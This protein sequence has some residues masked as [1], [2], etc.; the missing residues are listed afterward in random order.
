MV[1]VP[2]T[3]DDFKSG[4]DIFKARV[5]SNYFDTNTW[6]LSFEV[7]PLQVRDLIEYIVSLPDFQLK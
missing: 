6:T 3:V 1:E 5:P 7:A 4:V 2:Y